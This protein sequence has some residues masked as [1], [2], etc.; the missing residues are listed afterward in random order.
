MVDDIMPGRDGQPDDSLCSSCG[1]FVG[2]ATKCQY[3]G[4]PVR[5]RMSVRFFRW[6][7]V[8][9]ATVGLALLYWMSIMREVPRVEIGS[10]VSTM[11]FAYVNI[12]GVVPQ[13]ARI[14][15][16]GDMVS[17]VS[18]SVDDGTGTIPVRAF[19]RNGQALVDA[20]KVPRAGD[21]V[22]LD[23]SLN[24]SAD[25]VTL[26][27]QVPENLEIVARY[28]PDLFPISRISRDRLGETV[29]VRARIKAVRAPQTERQPWLFTLVDE[30][31]EVDLTVW[32]D[33][34]S[35]IPGADGLAEGAA[36]E[37]IAEVT[38]FRGDLRLTLGSPADLT[39]IS[40]SEYDAP[41]TDYVEQ[42]PSSRPQLESIARVGADREGELVRVSGRV[43]RSASIRGGNFHIIADDSGQLKVVLWDRQFEGAALEDIAEGARLEVTGRVNVYR[44]E[45]EVVPR[46]SFD[47]SV[48]SIDSEGNE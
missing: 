6:A 37:V 11:N 25:S 41:A 4:A 29:R 36:I 24:I 22:S 14:F 26:Y 18:F 16:T 34:K 44:E 27:L 9:L 3:C 48:Q 42:P 8:L 17:S 15:Q 21:R 40:D 10:I 1:R 31:G 32:R 45:L 43:L 30:D 38:S 12:E 33:V 7:A 13:S 20:D 2:P 47:I 23:G 35:A 5:Q 46:G 28:V 39:I 19:G